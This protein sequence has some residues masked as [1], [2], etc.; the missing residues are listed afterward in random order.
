MRLSLIVAAS[1]NGVIGRDNDMPWRLPSDLKRFKKLTMGQPIIMGRKTYLSIGRALPGR[2]NIVLSR[3]EAF[4][5]E[6]V[7]VAASLEDALGQ[8]AEAL[9]SNEEAGRD[10]C[11]VIGG[12]QI[13]RLALPL[14]DRLYLTRVHA[15]L[16]GDAYFE[17]EPSAWRLVAQEKAVKSDK[18]SHF[19]S[20]MTYERTC[21]RA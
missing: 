21:E 9:S 17:F 19:M 4:Q 14:A 10:E 3:D 5:A 8:A 20:F 12:A 2:L 11:F 6:G 15:E 13:Y 1:E 7:K 16:A 18:D